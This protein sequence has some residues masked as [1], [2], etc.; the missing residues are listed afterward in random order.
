MIA[1]MD[2]NGRLL[3]YYQLIFAASTLSVN[4]LLAAGC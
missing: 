4:R 2:A 3:S 1:D